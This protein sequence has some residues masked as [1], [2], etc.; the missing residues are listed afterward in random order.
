MTN[1]INSFEL[2]SFVRDNSI[3]HLQEE[4]LYQMLRYFDTDED[5][6]LSFQDFLQLVLPCEDNG[7]R[8][9]AS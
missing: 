9:K 8:K 6:R 7:L 5:G 1:F 3:Y 4:E 2:L